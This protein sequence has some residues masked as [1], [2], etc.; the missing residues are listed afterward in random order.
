M[1]TTERACEADG[2]LDH[3][4]L[5]GATYGYET[6]ELDT[7]IAAALTR[8][9]PGELPHELRFIGPSAALGAFLFNFP[10]L[11]NPKLV[12]QSLARLSVQGRG[13]SAVLHG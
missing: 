10:P 8:L 7:L 2:N 9:V 1:A 6:T 11:C 4:L 5:L 3:I 13:Q 12:R